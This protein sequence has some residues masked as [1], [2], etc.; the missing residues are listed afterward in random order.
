MGF[1]TSYWKDEENWA[2][3]SLNGV[4]IGY[5]WH[6]YPLIFIKEDNANEIKTFP[7]EL[8][9]ITIIK[10]KDL[11]SQEFSI[12]MDDDLM[13]RIS[14]LSNTKSFSAE[15]FWFDTNA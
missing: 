14:Y 4:L 2:T 6:K 3:F 5:I 9:Y 11:T 8:K 12:N 1:E 7:K 13:E 15:D 10:A